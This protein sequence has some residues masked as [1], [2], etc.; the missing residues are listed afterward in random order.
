M[1]C[2]PAWHPE[3]RVLWYESSDFSLFSLIYE[4]KSFQKAKGSNGRKQ[5]LKNGQVP[6]SLKGILLPP[7]K[8]NALFKNASYMHNPNLTF[9]YGY[10]LENC[11]P[12]LKWSNFITH[13]ICIFK[14]HEMLAF[15]INKSLLKCLMGKDITISLMV[16]FLF[17][18]STG[19]EMSSQI[20]HYF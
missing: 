3:I 6:Q 17:K 4:K 15:Q 19:R 20:I 2:L 8:A 5:I 12:N 18:L 9:Y 13:Y 11:F 7:L 1:Y 16:S 10:V 14:H